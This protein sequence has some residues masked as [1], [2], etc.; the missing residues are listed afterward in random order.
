[1]TLIRT[2][3]SNLGLIQMSDSTLTDASTGVFAREGKKVFRLDPLPGA[4]AFSGT[5]E[6]DGLHMDTW[7][8]QFIE[9]YLRGPDPTLEGFADK[10]FRDLASNV[11]PD[12][13]YLFHI[14]GYAGDGAEYHPE[15]WFVR[16]FSGIDDNSGEYTGI[17][18]WQ[19]SED[20]WHKYRTANRSFAPDDYVYFTNGTPDGR[21]AS[22]ILE[23]QLDPV[24]KYVRDRHG[25]KFRSPKDLGG[26]AA[27]IKAEFE[28]IYALFI[29]SDYE[30]PPI[31]GP[32]QIET[33][34]PPSGATHL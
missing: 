5:Y 26:F 14:V 6:A 28:V 12:A 20:F 3:I 23:R 31:G 4:L 19:I 15:M 27:L 22:V 24:F 32:T 29:N 21:I 1:M 8:P 7:M 16:N 17:G 10:L 30:G 25:W 18:T 34:L 33:I 13:G 2:V 9:A 11:S